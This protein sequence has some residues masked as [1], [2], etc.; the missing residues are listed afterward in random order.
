MEKMVTVGGREIL[1]RA[2]AATPMKYRNAFP[3]KDIFKDLMVIDSAQG[4]DGSLAFENLDMGTFERIAYI[5]SDAYA[6]HVDFESWLDGF[7]LMDIMNALPDIMSLW[8]DNMTTQSEPVK[9]V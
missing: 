5:M 7:E 3:G 9:N 8:E 4:E 2:T 6:K 1:F